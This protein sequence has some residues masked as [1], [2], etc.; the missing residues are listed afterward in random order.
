MAIKKFPLV[1]NFIVFSIV[2]FLIILIAG[3]TAFIFSMQ[4]IIKMN[5][6]HE[7]SRI[8]ETKRI[9]LEASVNGEIAVILRLANS[10]LIKHYFA[11]PDS[12]ELKKNAFEEITSYRKALRGRSLFWINDIDKMFHYDNGDPYL[13]NPEAPV[14]YWYN[15]T[16]YNTNVYNFSINYNPKMKETKLWI[17]APVLHTDWYNP[18]GMVG[19]G[20]DISSFINA[21][22]KDA[23]DGTDLY[24][25]NN[26]GEITGAKD[27]ELVMKKQKIDEEIADIADSIFARIKTL[28]PREIQ[29]FSVPSGEIAIGTVPVLNWYAIAFIPNRIEDYKTALT[30]LFLVMLVLIFLIFIVFNIFIYNFIKS[31]HRTMKS[32]KAASKAKSEFLAKMSHEI[33][34]PMNAI[35]GMSELAM[36]ADQLDTAKEHV[37]TIRQASANLLSIINDIL[38]FSKIESGKLEIISADYLFSSLVNDVVSIIRMRVIDSRLRFVVNVDSSIPNALCG[39][40]VRI[41]QVLLNIL[42]NAVKYTKKGFISFSVNGEIKEDGT[43]LLTID[44]ADSGKGIKQEDIE[45]LFGDFIRVDMAANKGIEGTG[46]GL[47]ITKNLVNAMGGDINIYSEYGKGSIFTITQ[48]QKIRSPEPLAAVENPEDKSVLVYERRQAYADSMICNIDNLGVDCTRVKNEEELYE[49]LK[50]RDY[51]FIFVTYIL[52]GG[53]KRILSELGSKAQIVALTGFGN[54]ITDKD[55]STLAM[56][57]HSISVANILN[58]ISDTFSY[59]ASGYRFSNTFRAPKARV[60]IVDD[61]STNLQVAEGLLLPYEMQVDLCLG[62]AEAIDAVEENNYDLVFMDHMMPEID[63][64]EATKRI[65]ELGE[66][67]KNLPIVALTANAVSGVKEMFLANGF[68]D[69]LS[70]PID[71]IKL[72]SILGKWLPKEKQEKTKE[73]ISNESDSVT[74]MDIEGVDIKKGI[75]LTGGKV[76]NYLRTLAVF[77]KDVIQKIEEIKKCLETDNYPLY[78]IYVHA[79]KSASANIGAGEISEAAKMLEFAGNQEDM[80]YIRQ[81]NAKFLADLQILLDNISVVISAN[82]ENKQEK[83]MDSNAIKNSLLKLKEALGT[84][85]LDIIDET[86]NDLR[87]FT[88]MAEI[89]KILQNILIGNYDEAVSIIDKYLFQQTQAGQV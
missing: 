35:V 82:S 30:G 16:L 58:G 28:K 3:S 32:L 53:V 9:E 5:K 42:S 45:K 73:E 56:P 14:N 46:L 25:V 27:I 4:Q 63:G 83:S 40:E 22:Y 18:L 55:L 81:H 44:V 62:G 2:L 74:L 19:I 41:R 87:E 17:N 67:Y 15:M 61:I 12:Q 65:R 43:V 80:K 75:T 1:N 79:L 48:P 6:D 60:L 11:A 71:T 24:F 52:L 89:E 70:K 84:L 88:R 34:T 29:T 66:R 57:V 68:N 59:S 26:L 23:A 64:V 20:I 69:F 33:R 78:T 51:S 50:A 47:A 85:D 76:K 31:L 36:R 49:K 7:L 21:V 72:N 8:L 38:D 10:P 37:L 54:T 39:D 77:H 86:V 13:I